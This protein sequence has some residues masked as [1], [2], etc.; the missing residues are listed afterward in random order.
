MVEMK[1]SKVKDIYER[2][3]TSR[4]KKKKLELLEDCKET[5]ILEIKNPKQTLENLEKENYAKL[6]AKIVNPK[7]S[8]R[9]NFSKPGQATSSKKTTTVWK[10]TSS[11]RK[12]TP[13]RKM[14]G[15]MTTK[16]R[17]SPIATSVAR[18]LG[19][20]SLPSVRKL[21]DR[22]QGTHLPLA[23]IEAKFQFPKP[24]MISSSAV[25]DTDCT[26]VNRAGPPMRMK[27]R[28]KAADRP[29]RAENDEESC[30]STQEIKKE[31]ANPPNK[32]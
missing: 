4:T 14:T 7:N 28:V 30:Q 25:V 10:T 6:K 32:P 29:I 3:K 19:L 31:C 18:K 13:T 20:V 23:Q 24:V 9:K 11:P 22:L 5:L 12:M 16:T 26:L 17:N 8:V 15:K 1:E 27:M 21:T 2:L